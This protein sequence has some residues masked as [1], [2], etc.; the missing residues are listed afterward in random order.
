MY[1]IIYV[2]VYFFI[3]FFMNGLLLFLLKKLDGGYFF[4]K[5]ILKVIIGA[6]LGSLLS[7][8]VLV[9]DWSISLMPRFFIVHGMI[10]YLMIWVS[11]QYRTK[12]Q[13]I[14]ALI[15]LNLLEIIMSGIL[16]MIIKEE[17][18]W[19]LKTTNI[20]T[21]EYQSIYETIGMSAFSA[22]VFLRFFWNYKREQY[23]H[24]HLYALKIFYE[25]K[26]CEGIGLLDTGNHLR[27]PISKKP[28]VIANAK[29]VCCLFEE[30]VVT[31]LCNFQTI[32]KIEGNYKIRWIPYHSLG[33]K[34]GYLV[35][36]IVDKL[37]V[38]KEGKEIVSKEV[39]LG[40]IEE[41]LS[42]EDLYQF[43][44]HEEYVKI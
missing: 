16:N 38:Y 39:L 23:T 15:K 44:L 18:F 4:K 37:I 9:A 17:Y 31:M 10:G 22:T 30:E 26:S 42:S 7:C 34:N 3:N 27:E 1:Y 33:K 6:F 12:R 41:E 40:M 25:G 21:I 13:Y 5:E 28:V 43:I 35:G 29:A 14:K 2:D 36:V 24:N 32:K 20:Q 8:L 19:K 11:F